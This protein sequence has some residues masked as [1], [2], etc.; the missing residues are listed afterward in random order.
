[1]K[2]KGKKIEGPNVEVIAI[3]RAMGEDIIFL[4]KAVLDMTSFEKMCPA[5]MP[6]MKM[7]AGGQQIPNLQDKD[8]LSSVNSLSVKRLAWIV[9]TSLAETEELEWETVD[10]ADHSTW[11]NFRSEMRNS[12][13]SDTE[14]NRVVA[15]CISA[16]ALNDEKIEAAR[17]RF[18]LTAQEELNA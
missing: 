14:I 1:M 8:Y 9:L 11:E 2:I 18:L 6:P 12:G 3:P 15:G 7:V 16:N 4:A 5:P 10:L 17:D 13:F